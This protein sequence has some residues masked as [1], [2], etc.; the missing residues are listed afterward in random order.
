MLKTQ[1]GAPIRDATT[2]D[3][4]MGNNEI[5]LFDL[6]KNIYG[7]YTVFWALFKHWDP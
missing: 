6:C 3:A 1:D 5:I 4:G 7:V 2:K